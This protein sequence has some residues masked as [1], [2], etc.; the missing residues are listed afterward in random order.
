MYV[1]TSASLFL[2]R[3]GLALALALALCEGSYR[4]CVDLRLSVPGSARACSCS[5]LSLCF[6][7]YTIAECSSIFPLILWSHSI[8]FKGAQGIPK[9]KIGLGGG[10]MG[11]LGKH[12]LKGGAVG[13][14]G[15]AR[16]VLPDQRPTARDYFAV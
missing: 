3:P 14:L 8:S 16:C 12:W 5:C 4:V 13:E 6:P 9:Y 1:W 10:R 2:A 11:E 7:P 15:E